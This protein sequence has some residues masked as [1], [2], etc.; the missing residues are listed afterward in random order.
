M[1]KKLLNILALCFLACQA[2]YANSNSLEQIGEVFIIDAQSTVIDIKHRWEVLPDPQSKLSFDQARKLFDERSHLIMKGTSFDKL[3]NAD[4][5]LK[6]SYR[7]SDEFFLKNFYNDLE[8]MKLEY[9]VLSLNH[10][11]FPEFSVYKINKLGKYEALVIIEDG[12]VKRNALLV[13]HPVIML[14]ADPG[15]HHLYVKYRNKKMLAPFHPAIWQLSTFN[16]NAQLENMILAGILF[17]LIAMFLYN[18]VLFWAMKDRD[19]LY[20]I[21]YIAAAIIT[22]AHTTRFLHQF[23]PF[24][25]QFHYLFWTYLFCS[26]LAITGMLFTV[27]FLELKTRRPVETKIILVLIFLFLGINVVNIV[28]GISELSTF[29]Y[30]VA[31]SVSAIMI[32][33]SG[34]ICARAGYRLAWIFL[35]AWSSLLVLALYYVINIFLIQFFDLTNHSYKDKMY[36]IYLG[37]ALEAVLMS[38]ALSY[39][40]KQIRNAR[41]EAKNL[42]I[43]ELESS[44]KFKDQFL[45][46]VGHELRT[47]MNGISGSTDLLSESNLDDIQREL[48]DVIKNSNRRMARAVEELLVYADLRSGNI[49]TEEDV[50]DISIL[51]QAL[52]IRHRVNAIKK[53]IDFKL[54]LAG[55]ARLLVGAEQHI[56][57]CINHL[58][59]NAIKFTDNGSVSLNIKILTM[60]SSTAMVNVAVLDSGCGIPEEMESSI[61]EVFNQADNSYTREHEGLGL[62]LATVLGF[63]SLYK[64]TLNYEPNLGGGTKFELRI[65]VRFANDAEVLAYQSNLIDNGKL[66]LNGFLSNKNALVVEDNPSNQLIIEKL[67]QKLNFAVELADN[68]EEG[69]KKALENDFDVIFMDCQMP[70]MDGYQATEILRKNEK[71]KNTLILAVTANSHSLDKKRCL[72]IGMNDY[73]RK[74][75]SLSVLKK[76]L[77]NWFYLRP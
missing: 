11:S 50:F 24:L 34:Y 29:L 10:S 64:G 72:E 61:F 9:R 47:P 16:K 28:F 53:G 15:L 70:I 25:E 44:H 51:S 7:F 19:Y 17:V 14:K 1:W 57:L 21:A 66:N 35:L 46:N 63:C 65:P 49:C 45:S 39:K 20:Y 23:S 40:I 43:S 13:R 6:F 26:L 33:W 31:S 68:G 59:N 4:Y 60:D 8:E 69:V 75:I 73:I 30:F 12:F 74:P 76:A 52:S 77:M 37:V 62:G 54:S 56:E 42:L 67:L 48:I 41:D 36:I 5:W 2:I 22:T 58:V 71:T 32:F 18:A 38:F 55:E 27:N 3:E